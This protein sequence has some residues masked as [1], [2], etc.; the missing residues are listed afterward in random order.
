MFSFIGNQQTVFQIG[1]TVLCSHLQWLRVRVAPHAFQH[2]VMSGV[3]ILDIAI[4]LFLVLAPFVERTALAP[5]NYLLFHQRPIA[6]ICAGLILGFLSCSMD[7][8]VCSFASV[9]LLEYSGFSVSLEVGWCQSSSFDLL[10]QYCIEYSGS[11]ASQN[12]VC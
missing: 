10:L 1:C 12:S 9:A 5:L 7:P 8:F 6:Y 2:S 4:R 11:S 3:P